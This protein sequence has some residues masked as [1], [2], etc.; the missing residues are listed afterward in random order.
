VLRVAG[1]D[2]V[3]SPRRGHVRGGL[4]ARPVRLAGGFASGEVDG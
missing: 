1:R 3:W 4:V 2:V